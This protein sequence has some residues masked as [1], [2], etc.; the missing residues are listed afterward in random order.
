MA[1]LRFSELSAPRQ[2]FIRRCQRLGFGT[3][4]SLEV[5]DCEPVLGPK[6]EVLLDLKLNA[7]EELRAEQDLGDFVVPS[8]ILRLLSRL[9]SIR[10]GNVEEIEVRAG[11]PR[12]MVFKA[13][14]PMHR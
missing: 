14:D 3:I 5:R 1:Q 13:A 10:D 2:A 11:V 8:E 6:T 9:D 7:E 4:R 12:R